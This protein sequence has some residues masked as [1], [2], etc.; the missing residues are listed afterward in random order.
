VRLRQPVHG[1][2]EELGRLV[3][4]VPALVL[5]AVEP[6]VRGQVHHLEPPLAQVPH[7]QRGGPVRQ[8]HERRVRSLGHPVGVELLERERHPVARVELVV[9]SAGIGPRRDHR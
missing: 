8:R 7:H 3:G 1:L 2:A 5:L 4:L 9:A 6:E